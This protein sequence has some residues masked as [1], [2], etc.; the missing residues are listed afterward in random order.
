MRSRIEAAEAAS[1][2]AADRESAA[3][4]ECALMEPRYAELASVAMLLQRRGGEFAA[5][6]AEALRQLD[7]VA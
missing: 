4:K 6:A 7:G 3:L 5:A 1:A 2:A